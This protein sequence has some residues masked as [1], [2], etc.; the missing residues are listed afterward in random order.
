MR[1]PDHDS[2]DVRPVPEIRKE[3]EAREII[4]GE[5]TRIS[6]GRVNLRFRVALGSTPS[7]LYARAYGRD[8]LPQRLL[9]YCH[10][11]GFLPAAGYGSD[12]WKH[13]GSPGYFLPRDAAEIEAIHGH[14]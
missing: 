4:S 6:T 12:G 2:D 7:T 10:S 13:P 11:Q 14:R 3:Y 8:D 9:I 1:V 5:R